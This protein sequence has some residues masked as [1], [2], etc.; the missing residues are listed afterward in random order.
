MQLSEKILMDA[1]G[2]QVMKQARLLAEAGRVSEFQSEPPCIRALVKDGGA[3]YRAGLKVLGPTRI[4][5]LCTCRESRQWGKICAHSIAV[6]LSTLQKTAPPQAPQEKPPSSPLNPS[7]H[8]IQWIP[9][10][11][12]PDFRLHLILPPN[13]KAAWEKGQ[14]MV[15][16]EAETS[17]GRMSFQAFPAKGVV[18]CEP[19]DVIAAAGICH[20]NNGKPSGMLILSHQD[21]T[22]F[23]TPLSGHQ[24]VTFGKSQAVNVTK[25]LAEYVPAK[26]LQN[27]LTDAQPGAEKL[28]EFQLHIE[29][30]LNNL[31]A[32]L[33]ASYD[34]I[35]Y[36]VGNL[37]GGERRRNF[38]VE[39]GAC[40]QLVQAG[41]SQPNSRHEMILQ[42][43]RNILRFVASELPKLEKQWKVS[44]GE[45]FTNISEQFERVEPRIQV[46]PSGERWFDMDISLGTPDGQAFSNAEIQRLLRSGQSHVRSGGKIVLFNGELLDEFQEALADCQPQQQQPGRYRVDKLHAA[47]LTNVLQPNWMTN[48]PPAW[49][50]WASRLNDPSYQPKPLD[51]GELEG[52]LRPYQKQGV[53]WM[54]FLAS[55]GLGGI[56]ADEMGLG[57]TLQTLAFLSAARSTEKAARP[58]LIVCPSSLTFNWMAEARRFVPG[59][60]TL[61]LEGSDRHEDFAQIPDSGLVITSYALLR[62]DLPALSA[63][64]FGAIVLDEAQHI[65]NPTTQNA[66]AAI[67]IKARSRFALTGTPVENSLMDLWSLMNFS[68]PGYLGEKKAFAERYA[69][70]NAEAEG[71]DAG[72]RLKKRIK[73]FLLR[74]LKAQVLPEL[75]EKMEQVLMCP[76]NGAQQ[77]MHRQL[78]DAAQGQLQEL[79]GKNAGAGRMKIL[80]ALTR[81]RQ[82]ACDLRLLGMDQKQAGGDSGKMELLEELLEEI[83]DS[84]Q[85]V[86]IFS[87]FVSMLQLIKERLNAN[88]I[89]F[90][91]LDGSTKDRASEVEKFQTSENI[92]VFLISLKAGGFGLN[93]TAAS[94][95]IHFDPWWNPA[96]EAQ[97][98]DRVHRIGQKRAVT[99]YK[100]IAAGSIEEKLHKLQQRKRALFEGIVDEESLAN[101]LSAD[102]LRDLLT[103]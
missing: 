82:T 58:A 56:L 49:R 24:R 32:K 34:D 38:S 100:L 62:R 10:E 11:G 64:E 101:Q 71:R 91:Y 73:P 20:F 45:R 84:G 102:D 3:Q 99:I 76:M 26:Q 67:R 6:G 40:R 41:F 96:T 15:V 74:R 57:K 35:P 50:E 59:M 23:F 42:G 61:L 63:H 66:Q 7:S 81:L 48:E 28:P 94:A 97:A 31:S 80:A 33:V 18:K 86:L 103:E 47:H 95:V 30:S 43:E 83:L 89:R 60:K 87:Q 14:I 19:W 70:P 46:K 22:L 1:G 21:F 75:P 68:L 72:L 53:Q 9:T 93:L 4:E 25:L 16:A 17:R 77:Q 8:D 27:L 29:G 13:F 51:L 90:C 54:H 39:D 92:P 65:K 52:I 55:Q 2:W 44:I 69:Q 36:T 85:R 98:S 88:K 12:P 78:I 79:S 5:N 37:S